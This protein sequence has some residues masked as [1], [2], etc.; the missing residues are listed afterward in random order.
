MNANRWRPWP[1][2]KGAP[3]VSARSSNPMG[4][5]EI[6]SKHSGSPLRSPSEIQEARRAPDKH[7]QCDDGETH[8]REPPGRRGFESQ[9]LEREVFFFRVFGGFRHGT[10]F[11][12]QKKNRC[13]ASCFAV[14]AEIRSEGKCSRASTGTFAPRRRSCTRPPQALDAKG[15]RAGPRAFPSKEMENSHAQPKI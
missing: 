11:F 12:Q 14:W 9:Q 6:C 10:P 4:V 1:E 15:N 2:P 13:P 7:Q 5:S 3:G 8:D